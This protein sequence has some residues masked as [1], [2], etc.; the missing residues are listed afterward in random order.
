[1]VNENDNSDLELAIR[2]ILNNCFKRNGWKRKK[3]NARLSSN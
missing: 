1:M 3:L 2:N